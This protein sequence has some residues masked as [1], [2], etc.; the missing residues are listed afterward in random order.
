M[1]LEPLYVLFAALKIPG[2]FV[3]IARSEQSLAADTTDINDLSC[4]RAVDAQYR[5]DQEDAQIGDYSDIAVVTPRRPRF[6]GF[7]RTRVF[8]I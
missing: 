2:G 8:R 5:R 1:H 3:R 4:E 6:D 7:R